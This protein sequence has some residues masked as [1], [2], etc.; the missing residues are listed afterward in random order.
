MRGVIVHDRPQWD[1][2]GRVHGFMAGIIVVF[3]ML[4]VHSRRNIGL[5]IKIAQ[6]ARKVLVVGDPTNVTFEM[7]DIN[8]IKPHQCCEQSPVGL[9][10]GIAC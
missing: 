1:H 6:I 3:D 2:A 9:C 8:R 10:D 7:S 5:L 4:H